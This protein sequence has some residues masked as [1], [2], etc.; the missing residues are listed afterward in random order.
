MLF[1]AYSF[2]L[3]AA[4]LI[5]PLTEFAITM[6]VNVRRLNEIA[7]E[8]D[9]EVLYCSPTSSVA[10]DE[11]NPRMDVPVSQVLVAT[12]Q[13]S[14]LLEHLEGLQNKGVASRGGFLIVTSADRPDILLGLIA[15]QFSRRVPPVCV[16]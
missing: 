14:D 11:V 4:I 1:V 8:I 2:A 3:A 6:I 13:I 10:N 15:G 7:N 16:G 12:V 5:E 9:A